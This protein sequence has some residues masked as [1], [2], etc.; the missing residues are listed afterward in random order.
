ME[1]DVENNVHRPL[2]QTR[3]GGVRILC[4]FLPVVNENA[5]SPSSIVLIF[6]FCLEY[7]HNSPNQEPLGLPQVDDIQYHLPSPGPLTKFGQ[8]VPAK[9]WP[10]SMMVV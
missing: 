7:H 2:N 8:N 1:T 4:P 5:L 3:G 6:F 9:L 10:N